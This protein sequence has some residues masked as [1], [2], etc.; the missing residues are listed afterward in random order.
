M[1]QSFIRCLLTAEVGFSNGEFR[2]SSVVTY[3][4]MGLDLL[5]LSTS[6]CLLSASSHQYSVHRTLTAR[7]TN[8]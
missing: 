4:A 7:M 2:M 5:F 6:R 3:V 8:R 1:V